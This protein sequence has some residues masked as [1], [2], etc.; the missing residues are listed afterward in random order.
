[1]AVFLPMVLSKGFAGQIARPLAMTVCTGLF[2]SIFVAVTIVP[3]IAS[4]LFQEKRN[5]KNAASAGTGMDRLKKI[6]AAL[7]VKTLRRKKLVIFASLGIFVLS[8]SLLYVTGF[9]FMPPNDVP[10][11]MLNGTLPVGTDLNETARVADKIGNIFLSLPEKKY[12]LEMTGRSSYGDT[13]AAMGTMPSDVNGFMI[14]SRLT[15]L[16]ERDRKTQEISDELRKKFPP[17]S[18]AVYTFSDMAG[19]MSGGMSKSPVE[20]KLFG[21]D[22]K[23]LENYANEITG[24]IKNVK[25]IRDLEISIQKG[26]PELRINVNRDKASHFGLRAGTIGEKVKNAFQGVVAGKYRVGGDDVDI[27]VRFREADRHT[28][29]DVFNTPLAAAGNSVIELKDVASVDSAFGPL[30]IER[31]NRMRKVTIRANIKDR[32]IGKVIRDV[33]KNLSALKFPTGYFIEYGGTYD[34]MKSTMK[35]LG[36]AFAAALVLI[37]MI[38]AAQFE[39]LTQPFVIMFTVPLSIIGVMVGLVIM[40]MSLSVPAMMGVI[41]LAGIVVNNGIVMIDYVNR[42]R[43]SGAEKYD[44]LVRAAVTRL[45]PIL[46]TSLTTILGVLPMAFSTSQGAEMRAPLGVAVSCGLVTSTILTLFVVPALYAV[47]DRIAR[48]SSEKINLKL[49]GGE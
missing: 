9:E 48:T 8:I 18:G 3:M 5:K 12:V 17:L 25:G 34:Q 24:K 29:G 38:M 30:K 42:L 46:I 7:L 23:K 35:D 28:S 47:V 6:Y 37:Y 26:K 32:A 10:M 33:K 4:V 44:A 39:S 27:R 40:G 22:L 43:N 2:A 14:M 1:I 21:S 13:D 49:H 20:I 31:E 45:R 15:D 11:V 16:E 19:S 36:L 41:V